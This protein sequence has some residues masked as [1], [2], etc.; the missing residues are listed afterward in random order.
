MAKRTIDKSLAAFAFKDLQTFKNIIMTLRIDGHTI[1]KALEHINEK[2]PVSTPISK[3]KSAQ[4]KKILKKCPNCGSR[5]A[6]F[7]VEQWNIDGNKSVWRCTSCIGC[8]GEDR[9]DETDPNERC[10]YERFSQK[11]VEE[12]IEEFEKQ[13]SKIMEN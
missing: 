5:L 9:Y 6:L 8:K 7:P 10:T 13:V 1:D 12:H 11:S 3:K 4:L 2:V